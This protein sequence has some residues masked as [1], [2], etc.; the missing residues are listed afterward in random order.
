[1]AR[2]AW[3]FLAILV[4][5]AIAEGAGWIGTRLGITGQFPRELVVMGTFVLASA[6]GRKL[7]GLPGPHAPYSQPNAPLAK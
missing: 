2:K 6:L 3:S 7:F 4:A 1:M 5:V